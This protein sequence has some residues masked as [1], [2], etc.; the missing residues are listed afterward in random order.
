MTIDTDGSSRTGVSQALHWL[1]AAGCGLRAAGCGLRAAGCGLRAA[2]VLL[3]IVSAPLQAA[4]AP[5]DWPKGHYLLPKRGDLIGQD[6]TVEAGAEETLLDLA[7]AHNLGY[8]EIRR[9]NPDLSVWMPGEGTEVVIPAQRLL[10]PVPRE[11]IVINLAE[12]RL[13]YYP[14]VEEGEAPRVETYPIGIGREGFDTP[15]GKTETTM[16][17]ENPAWYPPESVRQEA[18]ARGEQGPAGAGQPP[19]RPRDPARLRRLSHPRHQPAGRHRHA[20]QPWLHLKWS[21]W[22]GHPDKPHNEGHGGVHDQEDS[23]SVFR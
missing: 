10:P 8:E 11:G 16:R 17:I 2:V 21:N 9:A 4:G 19:R 5:D 12:L 18:A 13:Y 20:C 22:S 15:L 3:A 23:T 7:R 14:E 1:R 6:Y